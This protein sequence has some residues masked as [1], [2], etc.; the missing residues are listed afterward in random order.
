MAEKHLKK[1]SAILIIMEMQIKTTLRF[2]LTPVRMVRSTI[3]VT[4][5]AGEHVEKEEHSSIV[6]GISSLYNHSVNHSGGSSEN[7][8]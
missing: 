6:G 2:Y 3:H 8:T 1:C 5:D 4:A 7:W